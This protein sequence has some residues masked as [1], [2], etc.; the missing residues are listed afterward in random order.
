MFTILRIIV[1]DGGR[2]EGTGTM[3]ELFSI[4]KEET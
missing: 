3:E 2:L 4:K 1:I